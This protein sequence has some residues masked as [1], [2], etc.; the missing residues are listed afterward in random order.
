MAQGLKRELTDQK[1]RGLNETM[2]SRLI[3]D[4]LAESQSPSSSLGK[5]ALLPD[6]RKLDVRH[7]TVQNADMPVHLCRGTAAFILIAA[8][9]HFLPSL[10]CRLPPTPACNFSYEQIL[11]PIPTELVCCPLLRPA[12]SDE[13]ISLG[14]VPTAS[15]KLVDVAPNSEVRSQ[16]P[17]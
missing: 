9:N 17:A 5:C 14:V 13:A 7:A 10:D 12:A 16:L 1:I 15:L 6:C 11:H 8:C 2:A 3:L 4:N